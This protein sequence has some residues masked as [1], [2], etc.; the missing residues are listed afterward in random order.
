MNIGF[1]AKR[2]F[3]NNTGLGNYSRF[4][5]DSLAKYYPENHY[6]LFTPSVKFQKNTEPFFDKDNIHIVQPKGL[7]RFSILKSI[8]RS[9]FISKEEEV[10]QLNIYHGLSHELPA[11]LPKHVKKILTIHDLICLRYPQFFNPIDVWIYRKKLKTACEQADKIIAI[12]EETQKDILHF[13]QIDSAKIHVIYQGCN[14][15]YFL[16]KTDEEKKRIQVKY[17]LPDDF[18][19]NVG[20]IE[21]RKNVGLLVEALSSIDQAH[22][23]HLV[24]IGKRTPYTQK[25]EQLIKKHQLA[26]FVHILPYISF[27]DLPCIYQ[28][29]KLFAYSSL[30]EGFGIPIL[31]AM[32][33]EIPVLVPN[34]SCFKEVVGPEGRFFEQGNAHDLANQ[35]KMLLS[36]DNSQLIS[37]Q[38]TYLK[39]FFEDSIQQLYQE[40]YL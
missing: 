36:S 6:Y 9:Y 21:E 11:N 4:I 31:E 38:N 29:A 33:S 35:I 26:D 10:K 28:Q 32:V 12:S 17:R 40:V 18:I 7:F 15:V 24:L 1:D 5:V 37:Y 27:E 16:K 34:G 23:P 25:V 3:L 39:R 30:I 19:L 14:E 20:S 8:W 13:F 22:R 2:L